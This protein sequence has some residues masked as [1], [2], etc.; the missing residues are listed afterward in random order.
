[1]DGI[2]GASG[3]YVLHV[4][5]RA[6]AGAGEA[7][8]GV[9]ARC[10]DSLSCAGGVCVAPTCG[11][12][13]IGP[14]EQ[15]DDGNLVPGDGCDA[16]CGSEVT[17]CGALPAAVD[18]APF[19]GPAGATHDG[20]V[21]GQGADTSGTCVDPS[22]PELALA[23]RVPERADLTLSTDFPQTS[24]D[25]VLYVRGVCDN[26]ASELPRRTGSA[27]WPATTTSGAGTPAPGGPGRRP[28]GTLLY[29]YVDTY[30]NGAGGAYH[31]EISLTPVRAAGDPCDPDGAANR[32]EGALGC[33]GGL[34]AVNSCGDGFLGAGEGCDDGNLLPGDGCDAACAVEAGFCLGTVDLDLE[35]IRAGNE[36]TYAGDSTGAPSAGNTRSCGGQGPEVNHSYTLTQRANMVV[37][38]AA[39]PG[40]ADSVRTDCADVATELACVSTLM[41]QTLTIQDQAAG[42]LLAVRLDGFA[43]QQG[44]YTLTLREVAIS[45]LIG[46]CDG[47][48]TSRCEAGL[49][50]T[51]GFC[52]P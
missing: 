33:I 25:S 30:G 39:M 24:Y 32:C 23:Y 10:D 37:T 42:T 45:G 12:G 47:G 52:L 40:H 13:V 4:R 16:A 6:I 43:G 15:C 18:L 28:A 41:P 8:D 20:T 46:P 51:A 2:G 1:M 26:P 9:T 5:L 29:V 50:C 35:G 22:G 11:D 36:L 17:G 44:P 34:C 27:A 31:L 14:G 38:S 48:Q 49:N 7:C 21:V 19:G 3:S